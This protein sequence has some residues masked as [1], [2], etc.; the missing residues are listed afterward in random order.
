[1]DLLK[2]GTTV[3]QRLGGLRAAASA[4]DALGAAA[5]AARRGAAAASLLSRA[6]APLPGAA[7]P[8]PLLP[9]RGRAAVV[10]AAGAARAATASK[11]GAKQ[12]EPRYMQQLPDGFDLGLAVAMAAAAFEA[13]LE[14]GGFGGRH[15][16]RAGEGVASEWGGGFLA[17]V[18]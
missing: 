1:M 4:R 10:A 9:R 17:V 15:W 13:Y 14:P 6:A 18:A 12:D 2:P 5:A 3:A 11:R 16:C 7:A 8:A